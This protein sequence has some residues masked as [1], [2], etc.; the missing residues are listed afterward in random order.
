MTEVDTAAILDELRTCVPKSDYWT[1]VKVPA[2]CDALDEARAEVE[3]LESGL[4]H[5]VG[6]REQW[7]ERLTD[8]IYTFASV[9]EVGEWSSENELDARFVD[10]MSGKLQR[11]EADLDAA[12][13]TIREVEKLA[14]SLAS[15]AESWD[16]QPAL[17]ERGYVA[18]AIRRALT[19]EA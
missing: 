16:Q 1:Q 17:I 8:L 3:R 14:D 2:L 6:Q 10:H 7:E 4:E 5:E 15:D 11:L 9:A 19:G 12:R 18:A 13:A